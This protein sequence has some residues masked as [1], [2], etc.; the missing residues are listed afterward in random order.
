VGTGFGKEQSDK[1]IMAGRG[2]P[3]IWRKEKLVLGIFGGNLP[4]SI[5]LMVPIS[6]NGLSVNNGK[7]LR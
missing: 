5:A 4:I 6:L 7:A 2:S 3:A 1:N